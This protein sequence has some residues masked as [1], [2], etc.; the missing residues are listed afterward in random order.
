MTAKELIDRLRG[1]L[2]ALKAQGHAT[3]AVAALEEYLSTVEPVVGARPQTPNE[4]EEAVW[5]IASH[6]LEIWKQ[7]TS[8]RH[9][10]GLAAYKSMIEAAQSGLRVLMVINGGAAVALLAFLGNVLAAGNPT[11]RLPLSLPAINGAMATFV[12]GVALASGSS[13]FRFFTYLAS[14]NEWRKRETAFN[15][16]AIALGASSL[17]AFILGACG[18]YRSF[19]H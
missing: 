14:A 10:F 7:Q 6:N 1:E 17:A 11:A 16:V 4:A 2:G 8:M 12:A 15:A 5:R 9:E 19:P 13:I 18:A 3:V